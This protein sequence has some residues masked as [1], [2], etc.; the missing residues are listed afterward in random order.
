MASTFRMTSPPELLIRLDGDEGLFRAYEPSV[1][2][3]GRRRRLHRSDRRILTIGKT[4]R[5]IG[6]PVAQKSR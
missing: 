4:S 5:D 6:I 3:S 2:R 1:S